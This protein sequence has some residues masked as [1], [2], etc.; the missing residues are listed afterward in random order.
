MQHFSVLSWKYTG[1]NR[2][3]A[4]G[5]SQTGTQDLIGTIMIQM[6][7]KK[8]CWFLLV[9]G[10]FLKIKFFQQ[11]DLLISNHCTFVPL[12]P[13]SAQW[14][15]LYH[16]D[17]L[18]VNDCSTADDLNETQRF[19]AVPVVFDGCSI[20]PEV[21]IRGPV[22]KCDNFIKSTCPISGV[23]AFGILDAINW[24]D[25]FKWKSLCAHQR[26]RHSK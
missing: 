6:T 24:C 22:G 2:C 16:L 18:L 14:F 17:L 3:F 1:R 23:H 21:R 10:L 5:I 25:Y 13:S 20:S 8:C 7:E 19:A 15:S 9:L 4:D 26:S 12:Q 11:S